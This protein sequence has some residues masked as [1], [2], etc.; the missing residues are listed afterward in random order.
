MEGIVMKRTNI[1]LTDKQHDIIKRYSN[2][3]GKTMGELI[4][5]AIDH[6]YQSKDVVEKRRTVA[7]E[8]YKEGLLSLGRLSEVL[9]MDPV[10]T[11]DYLIEKG[12]SLQVQHYENIL[13]DVK[14]A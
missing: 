1:L 9:G 3:K 11:R 14:N 13:K 10:S 8:A 4:R 7:L 12:I 6:V 2:K 5:D